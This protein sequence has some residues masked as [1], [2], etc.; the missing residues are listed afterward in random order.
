MSHGLIL[1]MTE[2]G[3]TTLAKRLSH[4]LG[5]KGRTVLLLDEL[6]DPEFYAD[7]RTSDPETFLR[8]YWANQSCFAFID[9]AGDSVGRYDDAMRETATRG[10]HFGH[11]NFYISQRGAQ[12]NTTVRAQCRHL[13][14]FT[15]AADDC[16]ILGK[17]FN[18]P[19]LMTAA[20]LPAGSYLHKTKH[21]ALE[22]GKVF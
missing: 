10:R 20:S 4:A 19:E 18:C 22:R 17:E 11:S 8:V 2:S 7:F 3:K 21:G 14:L 6:G 1:G 5:G 16:K 13:W 9:E 15:S 12:L